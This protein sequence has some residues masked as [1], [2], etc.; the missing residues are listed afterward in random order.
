MKTC[1]VCGTTKPLDEFHRMAKGPQGRCSD[2]KPCRLRRVREYRKANQGKEQA[3]Q[4]AYNAKNQEWRREYDLWYKRA[5][6]YGLTRADFE[7]MM[8][9]Q[10]G[11]CAI[12][13]TSTKLVVD[14]CHESGRVRGLLCSNCNTGLGMFGDD[15]SRLGGAIE[16]LNS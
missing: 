6:K 16:Y 15:T 2:C 12:C 1:S 14:H 4:R 8:K 5:R 10:G 9:V 13:R 7:A 3:R 11:S